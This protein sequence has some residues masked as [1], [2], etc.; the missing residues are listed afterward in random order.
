[1]NEGEIYVSGARIRAVVGVPSFRGMGRG[2][3]GAVYRGPSCLPADPRRDARPL[4]RAC[5][6]PAYLH[7]PL[8][9]LKII[10]LNIRK[11]LRNGT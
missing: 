11:Q 5:L 9:D 1:M 6:L 4:L 8:E 7:L 10:Q 2:L 3:T